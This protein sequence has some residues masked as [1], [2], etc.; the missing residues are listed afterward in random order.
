[1][2]ILC[3]VNGPVRNNTLS[4]IVRSIYVDKKLKP[5]PGLGSLIFLLVT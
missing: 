1:M 2:D 4:T 5:D 3:Q